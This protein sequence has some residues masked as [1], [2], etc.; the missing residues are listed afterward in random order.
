MNK[1]E[2]LALYAQGKDAWN[3]WAKDMLDRRAEME[4]AGTW[5]VRPCEFLSSLK[6]RTWRHASGSTR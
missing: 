4:K 3:A 6:A 1:D 5:Q 2:T